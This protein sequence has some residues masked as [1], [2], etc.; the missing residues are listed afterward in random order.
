MKKEEKEELFKFMCHIV[1]PNHIDAKR[2]MTVTAKSKPDACAYIR[3]TWPSTQSI[4][5]PNNGIPVK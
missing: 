3:K 4:L 5:I 1:D 2:R